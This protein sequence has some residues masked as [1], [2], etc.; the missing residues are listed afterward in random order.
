MVLH[1]YLKLCVYFFY[2]EHTV[3]VATRVFYYPPGDCFTPPPLKKIFL[4]GRPPYH[5]IWLCQLSYCTTKGL[6]SPTL[7]TNPY[8][9]YYPLTDLS[10]CSM[11]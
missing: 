6:A 9:T 11:V 8:A 10:V 1:G 7:P 5:T 2:K 3:V 4:S